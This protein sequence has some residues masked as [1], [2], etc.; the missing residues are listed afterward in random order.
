MT[1]SKFKDFITCKVGKFNIIMP[2]CK[3]TQM[4][5]NVTCKLSIIFF[6]TDVIFHIWRH[7]VMNE[8]NKIIHT[9]TI[10]NELEFPN[11]CFN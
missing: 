6:S 8:W 2:M 7:F 4:Q 11:T 1:T 3:K 5:K 9:G 10:K